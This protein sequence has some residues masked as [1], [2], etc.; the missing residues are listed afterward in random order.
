[1]AQVGGMLWIL[2]TSYDSGSFTT[3]TRT[4]TGSAVLQATLT[5]SVSGAA[6][7]L[8]TLIRAVTV[9][10]VLQATQTVVVTSNAVLQTTANLAATTTA[11]L[12]ATFTRT[13][14]VAAV[15]LA[16]LTKTVT[17]TGNLQVYQY[18]RPAGD[19]VVGNWTNELGGTTN[20]Y[21][22]IDETTPNDSD[23]IQSPEDPVNEVYVFP[24]QAIPDPNSS[25]NHELA[26]RYKKNAAGGSLLDL[27]VQLRQGYVNESSQGTLI[28]A[29][30]YTNISADL[31]DVVET[32]SG[33]EADSITDYSALYVRYVAN[34]E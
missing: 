31:V 13:V 6:V 34:K 28:K 2:F 11:V 20:I 14:T 10:A 19:T 16:T 21:Q 3:E 30:T 29:W 25:V 26:I 15:V 12:L 17:V 4:V 9:T 5:C 1:M 32:L 27:T 24:L 18:A 23:Y 22:S 7:L 8:A 33:A